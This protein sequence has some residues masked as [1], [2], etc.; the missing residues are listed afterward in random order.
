[1]RTSLTRL[2][3]G[4]AIAATALLAVAGTASASTT[5]TAKTPTHLSIVAVKSTIT[6]GQWDTIG[7]TL[8]SAKGAVPGRAVILDKYTAAGKKWY[9]VEAKL[10]GKYGKVAFAV[11]PRVVTAYKLV[12]KGGSVYAASHSG[13]VVVK[14][15]PFVKTATTLSIAATPGATSKADTTISGALTLSKSGKAL[16]HQWVWLAWVGSKGKAHLE[17]AFLTGKY[18]KVAFKVHPAKTTTYEL[19]YLG[20]KVLAPTHSGT[21]TVAG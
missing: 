16:T 3:A 9:P 19:V 6:V 12:F 7:G 10:T 5:A 2:V 15:K 4:T 1:M 14:V 18:G 21:V 13:V 20:T 8:A 17:K 11:D